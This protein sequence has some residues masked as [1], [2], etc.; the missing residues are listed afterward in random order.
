MPAIPPS[1]IHEIISFRGRCEYDPA[2][3]VLYCCWNEGFFSNCSVT[4]LSL[5]QLFNNFQIIPDRIDFSRGFSDYRDAAQVERK[6]DLY[7]DYFQTHPDVPLANRGSIRLLGH[8]DSYRFQNFRAVAPYLNRFFRLA[9]AIE[10]IESKLI[11]KY[12]IEFPNTL[13]VCYRGSDKKTEVML[14]DPLNVLRLTERVL[15]SNPGLRLWIQT[16]VRQVS[17]LFRTHFGPRCF[18]VE[19]L[20]M[21][22]GDRSPKSMFSEAEGATR[23]FAF[24]QNL[25]AVTY[26]LSQCGELINHTGNMAYWI[27][28][29]RGKSDRMWQFDRRGKLVTWRTPIR[30]FWDRTRE[31]LQYR[32]AGKA[33]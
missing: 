31:F 21:I 11:S 7:P 6:T 28:L 23:R 24:G 10:R 14:A 15:E 29:F 32:V 30:E 26:M 12:G 22:D 13:A 17:D 8:H 27:W 3:K 9:P 20:P 5:I 4:L 2:D 25:L 16:E 19:E 33:P 1:A 18:V